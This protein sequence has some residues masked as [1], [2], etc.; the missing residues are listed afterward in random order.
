M[1]R[2]KPTRQ[3]RQ[4]VRTVPTYTIREAATYLAINQWTLYDWYDGPS[5]LLK[6]SGTYQ[7]GGNIK[8]LSFRDL[9]E[10]YKVHLLRNKFGQ[11]MQYL[12]GALVDA[13]RVTKS[14]HPLLEFKMI[15]FKRLAVELPAKGKRPMRMIP[16]GSDAQQMSMYIPDVLDVWGKRI[17]SDESGRAEQIY[18]WTDS[19]TDDVSRPV[20]IS[21]Q[22]LSGRLVV[23]GTRV[24]VDVLAGYAAS[25]KSA[26]EIA[27]LYRLDVEIVRKALR[28]VEDSVLQK[29]S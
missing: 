17:V 15:V 6:A 18:P 4:D 13:R 1:L 3:P 14:D 23:S 12:Q 5:P 27:V 7:G 29:A 28:H 16:L 21:S 26:E 2:N 22:V 8:L 10:A 9:E 19:A 25:G 24:P 11:S 20:S